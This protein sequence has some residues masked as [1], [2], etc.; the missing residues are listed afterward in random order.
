MYIFLQAQF[1]VAIEPEPTEP[2]TTNTTIPQAVV[3]PTEPAETTTL[4]AVVVPTEPAETT[5]LAARGRM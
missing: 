3:V 1:Q 4:A 2:V 5:T